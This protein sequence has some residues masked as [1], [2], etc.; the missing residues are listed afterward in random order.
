MNR[1]LIFGLAVVMVFS[2]VLAGCSS[3][4]DEID[5]TLPPDVEADPIPTDVPVVDEVLLLATTTSTQDSGL[6]DII[7]PDFTKAT[8]IK[9]DV[10]AVGTGQA[11]AIGADG[12]VDVVL[13][14]ARALEEQFM[15]DGHGVRREDVM[16]NDFIIV[17]P[18]DDPAG[19]QGMTDVAEA[20]RKLAEAEEMFISRGDNSGTHV[21][22][23]SIWERAGIDPGGNWYISAGQGMGDVLT[24][25]NEQQAYTLSDRATYLARL[26]QGLDLEIVVEGDEILFNPYGVIS[27]NPD[28][29]ADIR[30]ALAEIFIDWIISVPVQEKIAEFGIEEF[31]APLFIPD[32]DPW[33]NR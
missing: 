28:K 27:V 23:L 5:P 13:V 18:A 19:I 15:A 7:L 2:L 21:K 10:I 29:H 16:Y 8:G 24:M 30:N 3:P 6:L 9:V 20:F 1:K 32:S 12:N 11:I 17:G 22:E 25:T 4:V 33:R 31:G 14:H 26:L